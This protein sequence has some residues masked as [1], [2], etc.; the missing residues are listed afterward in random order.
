MSQFNKPLNKIVD[1]KSARNVCLNE[2]VI[3][4]LEDFKLKKIKFNTIYSDP[5]YN[6]DISYNGVK[7]KKKWEEYMD[8]YGRLTRLSLEC[9]EDDGHLFLLNYPKQN[10]H[11]RVK[12]IDDKPTNIPDW[13]SSY[14]I[15][16][17]GEVSEYVWI[18]NSN[19]GL[20]Q[21]KFTTAHRSILHITKTKKA[22]LNKGNWWMPFKNPG[23]VSRRLYNK[24]ISEGHNEEYASKI[25]LNHVSNTGRMPYSWINDFELASSVVN[26]GGKG[27]MYNDLVKNYSKDKT[28]HP[29]QIPIKLVQGLIC[30]ST[31]EKDHVFIHFGGSGNELIACKNLNRY[32]TS[33]EISKHYHSM[34]VDR[35]K[36]E[37]NGN[38]NSKYKLKNTK[39]GIKN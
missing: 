34:I 14:S 22:K 31:K 21:K 33:C 4:A 24:L 5:D 1:S 25:S 18:Y 38:L 9:L 30:S 19:I 27:A 23:P 29:C 2:D 39:I 37:K 12:Y 35:L 36:N 8:W 28:I 13:A 32:F 16:K 26:H 7:Y 20:S 3:A 10:S 11:L 6:V 15:L 17:K